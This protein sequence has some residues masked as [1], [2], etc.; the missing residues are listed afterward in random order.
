MFLLPLLGKAYAGSR[1]GPA[2]SWWSADYQTT[3]WWPC[4]RT[5]CDVVPVLALAV[6]PA[7][8]SAA[9]EQQAGDLER[10]R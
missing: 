8:E 3:E 5:C 9:L 1:S 6:A 7:V 4:D 10:T 2:V